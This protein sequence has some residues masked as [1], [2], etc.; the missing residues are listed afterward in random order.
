MKKKKKNKNKILIAI[1]AVLFII[2]ALVVGIS[3]YVKSCLKP[4][5]AFLNG[6]VCEEGQDVPCD[7][8]VFIVDEG[9]YG[10]STLDKLQEKGIIK[11]SDIVYYYNRIFSGYSFAAGYFELPH[12]VDD[13]NGGKR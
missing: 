5:D 11:N 12:T 2:I 9:A 7:F 13:G 3:I 1:F 6:Q 8:T 4:T 10:K